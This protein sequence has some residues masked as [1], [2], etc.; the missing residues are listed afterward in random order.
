MVATEVN[1]DATILRHYF[2]AV[3]TSQYDD[4]SWSPL[5][6]Q[7]E[8]TQLKS[9]LCSADLGDG[10]VFEHRYKELAANPSEDEIRKALRVPGAD[11]NE[12]TAAFVYVTGHGVSDA[13]HEHWTILRETVRGAWEATALRTIDLVMWL[14]GSGIKDLVLVLDMC[15]AGEVLRKVVGREF[16]P[17]WLILPSTAGP[18]E[19]TEAAF[20]QAIHEFMAELQTDIGV[21][22]AAT[23]PYL[24]VET[25]L[26]GVQAKLRNGQRLEPLTGSRLRGVHLA[27]PNPHYKAAGR[28]R[29]AGRRADLAIPV[30]DLE[31]HW[32]PR[33][34]GVASNDEPGWL[35]TGRARLM[36]ELIA[37]ASGAS[38]VTLVTGSA[39]CGKSA[40]LARLVTLSDP[41]FCTDH[42]D[43]VAGIPTELRPPRDSVDAAV[44]AT[45]KTSEEVF[46]QLR[47]AFGIEVPARPTLEETRRAWAQWT[48]MLERP[49]T[50]VVDALDEA[51]DP[52]D[53]VDQVLSYLADTTGLAPMV[54]LIVG[55]RSPGRSS[56][57]PV[58][59]SRRQPLAD[60]AMEKLGATRIVVDDEPWWEPEDIAS[61]S[62]NILLNTP[63]S[64]YRDGPGAER[65]AV[66]LAEAL[67]AQVGRSF[68]IARIAAS[69]LARRVYTIERT[70]PR[71]N[72]A[73][74]T[75][76][77]GVF[78]DDLHSALKLGEDRERAVQL[79]RALSFAEGRGLP[80]FQVWPIVANAVANGPTYGDYDIAWLLRTRLGAYVIIDHESGIPVYRLFHRF[81]RDT[82]RDGWED[83]LAVSHAE[84]ESQ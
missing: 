23:D 74:T 20:T 22:Y 79:L 58:G 21:R 35:F 42:N 44:V 16:P 60:W 82:L 27:L 62:L 46:A 56:D 12:S 43:V 9:W 48:T 73:I 34:R 65:R 36:R 63:G 70:D 13:E 67:C 6:V 83:L 69:S 30:G 55:V 80:W 49:I 71:W 8:L 33:S 76:V 11:W 57:V 32:N 66:E 2:V 10:R 15:A 26:L 31:T 14:R 54:R 25:F 38:G 7:T 81:L 59:Q 77:R 41:T 1:L 17:G 24:T 29:T 53:M 28:V 51:A 61:Y 47:E 84:V 19:A 18:D 75:G 39:G 40:A 5:D 45:G 68:L 3:A 72:N 52:S 50:I 4:P 37:R 64:P 78:R